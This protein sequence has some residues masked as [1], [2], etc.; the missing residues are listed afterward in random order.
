[1]GEKVLILVSRTD[2]GENC[3]MRHT[4]RGIILWEGIHP[5]ITGALL[6]TLKAAVPLYRSDL[7][8]RE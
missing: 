3:P 4:V 1:M 5:T 2:H 7:N 6:D 8:L